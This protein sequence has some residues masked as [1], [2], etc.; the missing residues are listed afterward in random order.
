MYM[1][2]FLSGRTGVLVGPLRGDICP[3]SSIR[4]QGVA[5]VGDW[6]GTVQ[7]VSFYIDAEE[8]R[9]LTSFDVAYMRSASENTHNNTSVARHPLYKDTW[10]G[11]PLLW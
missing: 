4:V 11:A 1:D 10:V 5:D 8:Q 9:A 7:G 3:G 6:Y 2:E